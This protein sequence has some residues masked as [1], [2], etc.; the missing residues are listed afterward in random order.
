[1]WKKFGKENGYNSYKEFVEAIKRFS[2]DHKVPKKISSLYLENVSFYQTPI[3][4]SECGIEISNNVESYVYIKPDEAVIELL[5]YG[6]KN[7][8]IWS[9]EKDQI[10]I[11]DEEEIGAALALATIKKQE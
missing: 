8:D 3:Y 5:E 4:L 10:E 9:G 2:K 1:M 6:K 11:I 7:V